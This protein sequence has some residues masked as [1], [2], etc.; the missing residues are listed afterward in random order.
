MFNTH[1]REGTI[2]L[3]SK[4]SSILITGLKAMVNTLVKS[5]KMMTDVLIL[6]LFFISIFA[7]IG[8]QL[9]LGK[10]RSRCVE[11]PPANFSE[12]VK[13]WEPSW[14]NQLVDPDV[15][16]KDRVFSK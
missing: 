3:L 4:N 9:F 2:F 1:E 5:M 10:L 13:V 8:L 11:V 7:L 6:T 15:D 16:E 12:S 14:Y